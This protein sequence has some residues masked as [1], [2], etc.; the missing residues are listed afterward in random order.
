[1]CIIKQLACIQIGIRG[2]YQKYGVFNQNTL[3]EVIC[4]DQQQLVLL[5]TH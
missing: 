1:M 4:F 2:G 3:N 5:L